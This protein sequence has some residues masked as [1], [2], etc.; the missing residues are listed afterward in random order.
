M[1]L[2]HRP[3]VD[4]LHIAPVVGDFPVV[5]HT[6]PADNCLVVESFLVV[7]RCLVVESFPVVVEG[8]RT[9]LNKSPRHGFSVEFSEYRQY[10]QGDDPRFLDWK[11]FARSEFRCPK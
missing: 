9:G 7:E 5:E 8:F 3:A 10:T 1:R 6:P 2:V 4:S 11:L